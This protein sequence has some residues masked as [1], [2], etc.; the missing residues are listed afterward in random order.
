VGKDGR[1]A[2]DFEFREGRRALHVIN[3]PS[4][5]ATASLA[6]AREIADRCEGP[7]RASGR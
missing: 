7:L 6:I 5:A 1:L 2:D 3:A 4:P